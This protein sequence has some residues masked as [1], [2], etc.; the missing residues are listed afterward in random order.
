MP[1]RRRLLLL[2]VLL[3]GCVSAGAGVPITPVDPGDSPP[4]LLPS[5]VVAATPTPAASAPSATPVASASASADPSA[6]E[7][8][9]TSCQGG[10][11]LEWSP[12]QADDFH[13]YT[14]LRSP[15]RE[16]KAAWPPIA[17]AV[18]WGDTYAVDRFVTS[19]VDAT[20]L[21]SDRTW[22]Y[23]VIA[24]DLDDRVVG[25][26]PVRRARLMPV[27]E[28]DDL[29][30]KAVDRDTTRLSWG[31]YGGFSGCFTGYRVLYGT[32]QATTVLA[33]VSDQATTQL[34]TDALARGTT[35]QLQVQAV[36]ITTLGSFVLGETDRVSYTVP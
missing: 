11:V 28:L 32:G 18:D 35:Y 29:A 22:F 14:A 19:A 25:T 13:H 33:V 10:V 7:L 27:E 1:E 5:A 16:I 3:S 12:S 4:I 17:P 20:I 30:A 8:E 31:G 21:P 26:S 23:R 9:A 2:A 34:D 36:R 15:E 24:Y 6:M